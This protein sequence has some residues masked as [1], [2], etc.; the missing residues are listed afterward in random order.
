MNS[1]RRSISFLVEFF[2]E[3]TGFPEAVVDD[4]VTLE[5]LGLRGSHLDYVLS[6]LEERIGTRD[7]ARFVES[8]PENQLTLTRLAEHLLEA[9]VRIPESQLTASV[10]AVSQNGQWQAD[11]AGQPFSAGEPPVFQR[12]ALR[13]V[14]VP[15]PAGS[16]PDPRLE[17]GVLLV[18]KSPAADAL[19]ERLRGAGNAVTQTAWQNDAAAFGA[20]LDGVWSQAAA[21]CLCFVLAPEESP[22]AG[23]DATAWN[24]ASTAKT[25]ALV[26]ACR[27]WLIRIEQSELLPQATL[28]AVTSLGGDFGFRNPPPEPAG[29]AWTGLLKAI[30]AEWDGRVRVKV[31]DS[32]A[33]EPAKM[34]AAAVCRELAAGLPEMEVSCVR[35]RREVVRV[36]PQPADCVPRR[37]MSRGGAWVVTGGARGITAQAALEIGRRAGAVLHLIGSRPVA[38]APN[39]PPAASPEQKR[40]MKSNVLR[41]AR[42]AGRHPE[43]AWAEIERA[44]EIRATLAALAAAGV[45]AVFHVCNVAD[46]ARLS[47]LLAEIRATTGPIR[48]VI[49]GAGF[50]A[51]GRV[52]KKTDDA[53]AKSIAARVEGAAGLIELT[54]ED[55]LEAF[56]AFGSLAG[57][58]GEPVHADFSLACDLTAK[59]IDA[60]AVRRPGTRFVTL[61]WPNWD[62]GFSARPEHQFLLKQ[63]GV[64]RMRVDEGVAHLIAEITADTRDREVAFVGPS[65]ESRTRL[66]VFPPSNQE[67]AAVA[68]QR[69]AVDA[70]VID[71]VFLRENG[72]GVAA[73]TFDPAADPF[74]TAHQDGSAPLLPAVMAIESCVEAACLLADA[75]YAG[76]VRDVKLIQGFRMPAP[77]LHRADIHAD[78]IDAGGTAAYACRLM[79][80][81]ITEEGRLADPGRLYQSMTVIPGR[82]LTRIPGPPDDRLPKSWIPVGYANSPSDPPSLPLRSLFYGPELRTLRA[83]GYD[84]PDGVGADP[85]AYTAERK[86]VANAWGKLIESDL[87]ELGGRRTGKAWRTP[88]AIFDGVLVLCD[89]FAFH[90]FQS[91]QLPQAIERIRF[92]RLPRTGEEC[93]SRTIC[94]GRD[95]RQFVFDLWLIGDNGDVLILAEGARFVDRNVTVGRK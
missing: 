70:P 73:I 80:N 56:V 8:L 27:Q 79:G 67:A 66:S 35:G 92:G 85:P 62:G 64:R 16:P 42:A 84:I 86:P 61:H 68:C 81:Y 23:G 71:S 50:E 22:L 19:A 49:H 55:P 37:A 91:K 74:L 72:S 46:R 82:T 87:L 9:G 53:I 48:G 11:L 45:K 77:V 6:V 90:M 36:I 59:L 13:T 38:D 15:I 43:S 21:T 89:M 18:G 12:Y 7:L 20:I 31:I 51:P 65:D 63:R 95:G 29:G 47:A 78:L 52:L 17:G 2:V 76:E 39:E 26:G 34:V 88:P 24:A 28:V 57:R 25:T 94:Y 58:F 69:R 14:E 4:G 44:W 41:E 60:E 54:R 75:P 40:E 83:V 33:G 10:G 1:L 32:A 93:L 5:F 3:Q 30:H